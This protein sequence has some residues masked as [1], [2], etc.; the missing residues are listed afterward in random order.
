MGP[1]VVGLA[2]NALNG[3]REQETFT[4]RGMKEMTKRFRVAALGALLGLMMLPVA[5]CE[6][7]TGTDDHAAAVVFLQ[8]EQEVARFTYP[9]P[10]T[11]GG[12][13]VGVN[14]TATYSIR[15][16][17]EA[18][19]PIV[20]DGQEFHIQAVQVAQPGVA[21]VALLGADQVI[22]TG[23]APG[24]TTF[25]FTLWHGSHEEFRIVGVPV[26]VG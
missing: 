21:T 6:S 15:V 13:V 7:P 18:G 25:S 10:V 14:A 2:W 16:L 4:E 3:G 17:T 22:V 12:L 19:I 1:P 8:G 23:V 9:G 26:T 11:G 24:T 5:G 20:L